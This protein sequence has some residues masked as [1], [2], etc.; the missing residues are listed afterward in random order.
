MI[1]LLLVAACGTTGCSTVSRTWKSVW[2]RKPK[3]A[4]QPIPQAPVAPA[5]NL[6]SVPQASRLDPALLQRPE[7][8]FTLGP[9]DQLEIEVLG[10]ATTRATVTVGP[11]GKI[12]YYLLPGLD[13]WGR[14]LAEA[15]ELITSE[16]KTYIR[17]PTVSVT[18]RNVE[19]KHVWL[20]GR[21][22]N[23]GVYPLTGPTTL[24][25]AVSLAGGPTSGSDLATLVSTLGA[26]GTSSTFEAADLQRSFVM[27]QGRILP[28]DFQRLLHDG[29][30]SQNIYLQPDDF[31]YLPSAIGHDVYV[32]GAVFQP[33]AV[34]FVDRLTLAATIA[35]AG[36]TLKDAYLSHVAIVRG[37]L[38]APQ[39]AIID[40][41]AIVHGK[42]PDVPV[43][44][45]DII[46]VPYTPY[47]TLTRYVNLILDTFARTV[48]VNEGARAV[49][50]RATAVGVGVSVGL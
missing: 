11:D 31:V 25:E 39:V 1:A 16:L 5:T 23:P 45:S 47:R 21:L 33:Q 17:E 14:T 26:N 38:S 46:Y 19:S 43:E 48:G 12:Y 44:P 24:L 6:V 3:H 49:S 20:L 34:N 36:G 9:G 35:N 37:S 2:H 42:A 50:N 29:D 4:E 15:R 18:L 7:K 32:L 8:D 28:V 10:D 41:D 27:R 30:L 40:Y 13:V 22:N